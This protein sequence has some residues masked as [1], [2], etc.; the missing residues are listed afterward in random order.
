MPHLGDA[1]S[2][3][4]IRLPPSHPLHHPKS[5]QRQREAIRADG[6]VLSRRVDGSLP[7][8]RK[9]VARQLCR[10]GLTA[11]PDQVLANRHS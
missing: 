8:L 4:A 10:R 2:G 1:S 6:A 7:F 11:R 3:K 9:A 5:L